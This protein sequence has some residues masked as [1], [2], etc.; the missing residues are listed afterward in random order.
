MQSSSTLQQCTRSS[1]ALPDRSL[2]VQAALVVPD[3]GNLL[4]ASLAHNDL[5]ALRPHLKLI[6]LEQH[7]VLFEAGHSVDQV[8]FPTSAIVSLVIGLSTGE[9]VETAMVGNDGAV[10]VSAALNDR[11]S[12]IRAVV[13]LGGGSVICSTGGLKA[14]AMKSPTLLSALIR[15][16]DMRFATR[17]HCA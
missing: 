3:N 16:V 10:G 6:E 12:T 17:H 2:Q 5:A 8:Y 15:H 1:I 9:M 4:L 13:Q 11:I 7:Q 14:A